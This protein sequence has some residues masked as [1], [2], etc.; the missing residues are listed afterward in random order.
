MTNASFKSTTAQAPNFVG[1][2]MARDGFVW[3]VHGVP[4]TH[5]ASNDEAGF[6]AL[7]ASLKD[8]QIGLIVIEATGGLERA[9]ASFLL[10]NNLPVAVAN[11]RAARQFARSMGHLAKTDAIDSLALAH[12]AQTL[13]GK[14][15]Q[16]GVQF[17]PASEQVQVLQAMVARRAQLLNMRTAE[18]NRLSG[19]IRVLH[20]SIQTVIKTL[21]KEVEQLDKDINRHLDLHFKEQTR[22]FEAIKGIGVTTCATL[23][24]FMPELGRVESGRAAKLAGLAPLNQDSGQH[25]GKRHIW[26]GRSIVRSTL[27]MA[28]LSAIRFNPVIKTFYERLVAAG[29]PKKVAMTAC[30]H[31]MLRIINAMARTGKPW[32]DE[33]HAVQ[34]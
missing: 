1:V 6:E 11:P 3:S 33:Y 18:K 19:A 30:S 8:L 5:S 17:E 28:T 25:R 31:K 20:K 13:A 15:D 2:D 22:R 10:S 16:A 7:R 24:A 21:D 29:K 26:G 27:H 34:P 9:L 12:Y 23:L 4:G 32:S 14:A